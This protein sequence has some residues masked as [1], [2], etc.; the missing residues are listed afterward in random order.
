MSDIFKKN[1]KK[2]AERLWSAKKRNEKIVIWGDYDADGISGTLIALEALKDLGFQNVSISISGR[3]G[4]YN[5]GE[6]AIKRFSRQGINLIVSVDFGISACKEVKFARQKGIDFIVL[7]HHQPPKVLPKAIVANWPLKTRAGTGV[8]FELVKVLYKEAKKPKEEIEKFLD[9]AAVA[10]V[11]DK[12]SLT[13]EN[14]KIISGGVKRINGGYRPAL[15]TLSRKIN[16][17]SGGKKLTTENFHKLVDRID[18]PSGANEENNLFRLMT[19]ADKKEIRNLVNSIYQNY[20]QAEKTI[21]AVYKDNIPKF[22][23]KPLPGVIFVENKFDWPQSGINGRVADDFI[24]KL[25]RPVFVYGRSGDK[26]KASGRAMP[27]FDLVKALRSCPANLFDNSGGHPQAAGFKA[28]VE[29]LEKIE[30][31]MEKYCELK[32]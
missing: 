22:S 14:K 27:G 8:V 31:C 32:K 24:R 5:K 13:E 29:N 28:P 16:P 2:A 9:L 23:F 11:A 10:T 25:K 3:N 18:F 17:P 30:Q 20:R 1:I 15:L 21:K 6:E 26:I 19:I 12:I 7:D 4:I